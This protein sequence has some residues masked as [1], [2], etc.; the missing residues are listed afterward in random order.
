MTLKE[1]AEKIAEVHAKWMENKDT[2]PLAAQRYRQ[3]YK[4]Q[5]MNH[6]IRLAKAYLESIDQYDGEQ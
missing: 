4:A 5:S 1:A 2:N 6:A 3:I